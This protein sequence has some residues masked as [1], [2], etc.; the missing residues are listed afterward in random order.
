MRTSEQ[1]STVVNDVT[2]NGKSF[3]DNGSSVQKSTITCRPTNDASLMVPSGS[4]LTVGARIRDSSGKT[5]HRRCSS[6]VRTRRESTT[7]TLEDRLD[8]QPSNIAVEKTS[9][10][11]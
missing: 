6:S 9:A 5:K 10:A 11:C 4:T 1:Q 3:T 7:C 2:W 8:A